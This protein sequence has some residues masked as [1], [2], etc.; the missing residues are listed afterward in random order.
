MAT[1]GKCPLDGAQKSVGHLERTLF[2]ANGE[3]VSVLKTVTPVTSNGRRYILDCFVNVSQQKQAEERQA[4]SLARLEGLN[5][6]REDLLLP[7]SPQEKYKKVT[8]AAAAL[9]DL[10]FLPHLDSR[11]GATSAT[12]AACTRQLLKITPLARTAISACIWTRVRDDT[13]I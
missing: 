4:R 2:R 10:D 5:R 9:L 8:E 12:T 3:R 13:P 11:A 1:T 6:L 7:G